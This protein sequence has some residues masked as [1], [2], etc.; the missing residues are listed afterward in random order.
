MIFA[1]QVTV[2]FA[3][4]SLLFTGKAAAFLGLSDN[5]FPAGYF[6]IPLN[7]ENVN[8]LWL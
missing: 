5:N 8:S 2:L 6:P 3:I 4:G 1:F 7:P